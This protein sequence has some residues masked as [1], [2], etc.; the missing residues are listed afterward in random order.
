MSQSR[1]CR[2]AFMAS[3]ALF[4]GAGADAAESRI[5]VYLP[6]SLSQ[7]G[8]YYLS[9]DLSGTLDV[10]E[11]AP[12]GG[13]LI[14]LNGKTIN[15]TGGVALQVSMA[16]HLTI[17]NGALVGDLTLDGGTD[18]EVENVTVRDG[19]VV[20]N[21]APGQATKVRLRDIRIENGQISINYA[22]GVT[23]RDVQIDSGNF[24]DSA[25]YVD[26]SEDVL[27]DRV[28]VIDCSHP[29]ALRSYYTDG[30]RVQDSSFSSTGV[31]P[32]QVS[33]EGGERN[34]VVRCRM[35]RLVTYGQS[36]VIEDN[37]IV[38]GGLRDDG[39]STILRGNKVLW[40]DTIGMELAGSQVTAQD[41][42]VTS[43]S[44]VGIQ[45]YSYIGL[46]KDNV[47]RTN[48]GAGIEVYDATHIIGNSVHEN[49]GI[50]IHIMGT[51]NVFRDNM[52]TSN[53]GG[54]IVVDFPTSNE[55]TGGTFVEDALSNVL[56]Y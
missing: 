7:S 51:Y 24:I 32:P 17:R 48:G 4:L 30:I 52:V 26:S 33:I 35:G 19:R 10:Y 55:P 46:L 2:F 34:S 13:W 27:I 28:R 42:F 6:T 49:V 8:S 25:V 18:L 23:V 38:G 22:R 9:E 5:P 39:W 15:A 50:G 56:A 54:S 1:S 14:D 16:S 44:G 3:L 29:E 40:S 36:T 12:G 11:Y 20:V 47:V 43:S 37:E 53:A 31:T 41:N 21:G 45:S